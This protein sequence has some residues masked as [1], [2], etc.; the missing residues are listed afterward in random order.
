MTDLHGWSV[1]AEQFLAAILESVAQPIWVVDPDGIIRFANPAAVTALGYESAE[2]LLGCPSHETI[3]HTH[4]DGTH[5]PAADCPMLLPRQTG[6]RVARER[7]WFFRRDGTGFPVSYVSVPI[8]LR[9]GRGAVVVFVPREREA[10]LAEERAALLRI[11]TLVAGGAASRDVLAAVAREIGE[12]LDLPVVEM[13]RLEPDGTSA[14]VVGAWG[15]IEHPFQVGTRWQLDGPTVSGEVLR[16]GRATRIEDYTAIDGEIATAVRTS[17]IHSGVGVPIVVEGRLWGVM[18]TGALAGEL[19]PEHIEERLEEFTRLLAAAISN[20]QAREELDRIIDEQSALRRIATLVAQDA[21]PSTIFEAVCAETGRIF[22]AS[23]VNLAR[24]SNGF[25]VTMAGWSHRAVHVPTG[26]VLPLEGNSINNLVRETRAPGRFDSYVG[27]TGPLA[28][29]LRELGIRSE[30]GAPVLVDGQ[31]WGAL[32]AGTDEPGPLPA[33]IEDRLA[34][35]AELIATAVSNAAKRTELLA[36]RAR[37]LAAQ[38]EQRRQVVRDL[39]DG[40]QQR[41]V[42]AVIQLQLAA[43]RDDL[44]PETERLVRAALDHAEAAIEELRELAH[45]IHPSV[46]TH[47]GLAA[48]VDALAERSPLP[49]QARIPEERFP[50]AVESAAYFIVAES[51][52]NAVKHA[53]ATVMSVSVQRA[54]GALV[55]DVVD[56]GAGG[57][58]D[59]PGGGLAGLRD[60]VSAI[61]GRLSLN[62]ESGRGT[63]LR[64]ELPLR[65]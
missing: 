53:R 58:I 57:A 20:T 23:T 3:H 19:L 27:A 34:G 5:F 44:S 45:G 25:N 1:E 4:P 54:N 22:N 39:H 50:P 28:A 46:L 51:L 12:L 55:L 64:V 9:E 13:S 47:Y 32:I 17:G 49:V 42:N 38:D 16:T 15:R 7:D 31:V 60:R 10:T 26:T 21:E 2:Q 41:L 56:D 29:R 65:S 48:A 8:R 61:D 14:V 52:T 30:V 63:H 36:S 40:A 37:I 33:G 18:A 6:E 59:K 43:G 24:F 35:F 62:S 11:A